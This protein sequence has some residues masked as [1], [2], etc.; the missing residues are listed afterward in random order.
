[1]KVETLDL[2]ELCDTL[3]NKKCIILSN[4]TYTCNTGCNTGK[5][6]LRFPGSYFVESM[7]T[8]PCGEIWIRRRATLGFLRCDARLR[9]W[10]KQREIDKI[11]RAFP[12]NMHIN[13]FW[14]YERYR[15]IQIVQ[16]PPVPQRRLRSETRPSRPCASEARKPFSLAFHH[17]SKRCET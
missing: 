9:A 11:S 5:A 7:E 2:S 6:A 17:K 1:M 15:M 3:S 13:T 12:D 14:K 4:Q 16:R 8:D 10:Q